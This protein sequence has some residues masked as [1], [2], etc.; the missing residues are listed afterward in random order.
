MFEGTYLEG[1][2][3]FK[4]WLSESLFSRGFAKKN[5]KTIFRGSKIMVQS[6][7]FLEVDDDCWDTFEGNHFKH[8]QAITVWLDDSQIDVL[9]LCQVAAPFI[10]PDPVDVVSWFPV[11]VFFLEIP[12]VF[13]WNTLHP[14]VMLRPIEAPQRQ[15]PSEPSAQ[16]QRPLRVPWVQRCWSVI[17]D[18]S[19]QD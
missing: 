6:P 3:S 9:L 5:Q 1:L 18:D 16:P 4:C 8:V 7:S 2:G 15:K 11:L 19:V 12:L 10:W 13:F 14:L 17:E